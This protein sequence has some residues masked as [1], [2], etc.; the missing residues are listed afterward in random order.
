[1]HLHRSRVQTEGFDANADNLLQLQLLKHPIQNTALCPTI[2]AY[3]DRMPVAEPLGQAASL[4]AMLSHIEDC[5]E[6]LQIAQPYI[7]ALQR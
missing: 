7:P 2:H 5:V 3:V 1:M 6:H 4:A